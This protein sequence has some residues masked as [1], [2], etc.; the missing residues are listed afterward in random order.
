MG[1]DEYRASPE[2]TSPEAVSFTCNLAHVG[3]A[4]DTV[5][6]VWLLAFGFWLLALGFW[7]LAFGFWHLDF[8][9][10]LLAFGFW[11]RVRVLG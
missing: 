8:G 11:V 6:T 5:I 9:F 3:N 1:G 10:W 4:I 7:R 2:M